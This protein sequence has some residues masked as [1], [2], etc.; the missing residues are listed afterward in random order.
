MKLMITSPQARV[1]MTNEPTVTTVFSEGCQVKMAEPN[2][3]MK[4]FICKMVI[5][6]R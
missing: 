4:L 6:R 1:A 3:L 5:T 2:Q